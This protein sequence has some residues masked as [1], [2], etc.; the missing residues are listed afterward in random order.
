MV[1]KDPW[2]KA[3]ELLE[4]LGNETRI[5]ILRLLSEKQCYVSEIS[6]ELSV[7][8]QAILRHLKK[9]SDSNFLKSFEEV[10]EEENRS[11]G[12]RRKYYTISDNSTFR[13]LINF[14]DEQFSIQ[15]EE[16][17]DEDELDQI[18][19]ILDLW[20]GLEYF[21]KEIERIDNISNNL[22]KLKYVVD[23]IG[24]LDD[25]YNK[26]Y[27]AIQFIKSLLNKLYKIKENIKT[28]I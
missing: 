11:R 15:L 3:K 24:R 21:K 25:E 12:R 23:M 13:L 4:L 17:S 16:S 2:K 9:L 6:R 22:D 10:I 14:S 20:P 26:H 8:Q 28:D 7:G 18:R 1:I 27:L 19:Y 5:E